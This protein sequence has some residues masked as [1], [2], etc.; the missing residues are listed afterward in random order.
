[1]TLNI[2]TKIQPRQTPPVVKKWL[3]KQLDR[4][5]LTTEE[6]SIWTTKKLTRKERERR[7]SE[8][9]SEQARR[10]HR[11]ERIAKKMLKM[12]MS[13]DDVDVVRRGGWTD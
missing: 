4:R 11:L 9:E 2:V 3:E 8:W 1:M 6:V 7:R 5:V 12:G 13:K 10:K